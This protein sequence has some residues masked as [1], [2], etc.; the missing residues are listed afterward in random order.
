MCRPYL[1]CHLRVRVAGAPAKMPLE[2][3]GNFALAGVTGC[4]PQALHAMS[5][6]NPLQVQVGSL[7]H[8]HPAFKLE[9]LEVARVGDFVKCAL[10]PRGLSRLPVHGV[11][12]ILLSFKRTRSWAAA[13]SGPAGGPACQSDTVIIRKQLLLSLSSLCGNYEI[14]PRQ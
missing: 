4:S 1:L 10:E 11:C 5:P 6:W 9:E 12:R 7:S 13:A 2:V 3:A 14:S 8:W